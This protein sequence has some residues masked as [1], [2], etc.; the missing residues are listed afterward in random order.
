MK[1]DATLVSEHSSALIK[2]HVRQMSRLESKNAETR[3]K[4]GRPL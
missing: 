4:K 2:I 3:H 1:H